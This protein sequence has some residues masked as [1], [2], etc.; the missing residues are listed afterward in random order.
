MA[1]VP[2]LE[3]EDTKQPSHEREALVGERT[4][5]VNRMKAILVRLGVRGFNPTLKK[6]P[7][8]LETVQTFEGQPIPPITA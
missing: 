4:R 3:Q 7:E 5:I 1:A 2:T 6:A 8:R